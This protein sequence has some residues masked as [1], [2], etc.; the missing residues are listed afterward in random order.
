M[1]ASLEYDAADAADRVHET[2]VSAVARLDAGF[3]DHLA[4]LSCEVRQVQYWIGGIGCG[5]TY[6]T[7]PHP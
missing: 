5:Q 2:A 4:P 3:G 7:E 6:V 1:I